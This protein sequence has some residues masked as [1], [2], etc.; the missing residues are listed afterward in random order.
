MGWVEAGVEAGVDVATRLATQQYQTYFT[1]GQVAAKILLCGGP[2]KQ[3]WGLRGRS[4]G[5][6]RFHRYCARKGPLW[7]RSLPM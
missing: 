5:T 4:P 6:R 2:K 7:L 1:L 3:R